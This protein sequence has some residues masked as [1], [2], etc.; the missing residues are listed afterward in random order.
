M[1]PEV[2]TKEIIELKVDMNV[3]KEQIHT[4]S[5]L[6][7]K[8]DIVIEKLQSNMEKE[9]RHFDEHHS[10]ETEKIKVEMEKKWNE[11][12]ST[13]N[14]LESRVVESFEV[15]DKKNQE[16]HDKIIAQMNELKTWEDTEH[17]RLLKEI[18]EL[19]KWKFYLIGGAFVIGW[20]LTYIDFDKIAHLLGHIG[21]AT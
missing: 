17:G 21:K 8:M 6:C 16:E 5:V 12:I 2:Q 13:I 20:L 9:I 11:L 10:K 3:A 18:S 1:T 15:M 4:L 14:G 7:Q 19:K